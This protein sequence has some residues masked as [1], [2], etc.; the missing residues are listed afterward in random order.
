VVRPKIL[1]VLG[2]EAAPRVWRLWNSR[3]L[4]PPAGLDPSETLDQFPA[5]AGALGKA[6]REHEEGPTVEV[7]AL[8]HPS[9]VEG[10]REAA[11]VAN[12]RAIAARLA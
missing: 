4:L 12:L 6:T 10:A 5:F 3:R 11:Y 7:F 8:K 9:Y 1:I 2:G